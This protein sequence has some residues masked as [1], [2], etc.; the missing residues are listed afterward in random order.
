M[1]FTVGGIDLLPYLLTNYT[2]D[3]L[4]ENGSNGFTAENG[5]IISDKKGDTVSIS[6]VLHN[7]PAATAKN[8]ETALRAETF[9]CTVSAPGEITLPFRMTSYKSTEKN[10]GA[11]WEI[12][13]TIA[14]ASL[15]S[16]G[17]CL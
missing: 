7:V 13:F 5:D 17:S 12:R 10:K 1:V 16:T 14:S 8:I 4:P 2:V 9:S 11:L 6:A 15:L 3:I